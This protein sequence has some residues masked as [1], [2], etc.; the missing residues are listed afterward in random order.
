MTATSGKLPSA[1]P[2]E[3]L[4]AKV[5][6]SWKILRRSTVFAGYRFGN[7]PGGSGKG[8]GQRRASACNRQNRCLDAKRLRAL[9]RPRLRR[10]YSRLRERTSTA[11]GSYVCH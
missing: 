7:E 2:D 6:F 1:S 3:T 5:L 8:G 11:S 9:L 10:C 4:S